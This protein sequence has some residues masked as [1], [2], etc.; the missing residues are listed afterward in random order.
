MK[1]TVLK[2]LPGDFPWQVHWF[3][4]VDSTNDLAKTLAKQGAPHGTVL[5]ADSQTKGRGRL[6]RSFQSPAGSGIYVSVLL[7]PDCKAEALLHLTCAVAVAVCDG[8]EEVC[9]FRP[10]VKWINDFVANNRKL[11]GILTELSL[12]PDGSV[13]HCII[14]IGIN[15]LKSPMPPELAEIAVS[16]Q[17]V[18]GENTD[19]AMLTAAILDRL[20]HMSR[21]LHTEKNAIMARYREDCVT[22]DRQVVLQKN[23]DSQPAYA[24]DID[25]DG[26][27]I[28]QYPDGSVQTVTS[29]EASVRGLCGYL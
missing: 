10:G 16:I 17:E 24:R 8:I 21:A 25:L 9:G 14:G 7:R 12:K 13:D 20:L 3:Q 1:H 6:G 26:G 19:R 4:C 29:G 27:L 22:L 5:L 23:G 28:V 18:T 2:H 11:G 15:C